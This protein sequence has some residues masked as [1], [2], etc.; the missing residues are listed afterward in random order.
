MGAV[1]QPA[2]PEVTVC[3]VSFNTRDL[4]RR[5]LES[6]Y[7]AESPAV[8]A[9]WE[10]AGQP[11]APGERETVPFEVVVVDQVSLDGS[12]DMVAAE[13]PQAKLIHLQQNVGFAGGNN[14]AF[15]AGSGRFFLLLN[16]DAVARP[17]LLA[18]LLDFAAK[19]PKAGL[20]GPKVLN[21][22]GSLQASCRRFPSLG[23]GLFRN[24][25]LGRLFP[26]NRYT[27]EYLMEEW[28][29]TV[30]REVD[31]LSACCLLARREMVETVGP[32]DETYF[33]YFEDVDWSLRAA[34]GGWEVWYAPVAPVVH[35]IGRSTDKAVKRMIVRHHRSAYQFFTKHYPRTRSLPAR[36]LLA[37]G[38]TAR[39]ILTLVRNQLLQWKLRWIR[40]RN[41]QR[42]VG[43]GSVTGALGE[44]ESGVKRET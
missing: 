21:A 33:M 25:F 14:L 34:R 17:G 43:A 39:C 2:T 6:L 42:A 29:H 27:R 24:T 40:F 10:A 38:L 5:C 36:A 12:A 32:M 9:A 3:I 26:H 37:A 22:D 28:D 35:E 11:L 16:S 7:R 30:P 1:P 41:R 13:F 15:R 4:L 18:A 19:H 23:A 8:R 44:A 20:I 31:W